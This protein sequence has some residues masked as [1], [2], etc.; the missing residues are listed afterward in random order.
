MSKKL[1]LSVFFFVTFI[2]LNS[3]E[4]SVIDFPNPITFQPANLGY[5]NYNVNEYV[6]SHISLS[7][8]LLNSLES[9]T[10]LTY[11]TIPNLSQSAFASTKVGTIRTALKYE[12]HKLE[13]KFKSFLY[14]YEH[15][16]GTDNLDYEYGGFFA[17]G[18]KYGF[19]FESYKMEDKF[20]DSVEY[21][22]SGELDAGEHTLISYKYDKLVKTKSDFNILGFSYKD[23]ASIIIN[24]KVGLGNRDYSLNLDFEKTYEYRLEN[25]FRIGDNVQR[26]IFDADCAYDC[27][28]Y[29]LQVGGIYSTDQSQKIATR[30]TAEVSYLSYEYSK[31]F[32]FSNTT[33]S[34]FSSDEEKI[35]HKNIYSMKLSGLE[36]NF[37]NDTS[38]KVTDKF[39]VSGIIKVNFIPRFL[40]STYP[41]TRN[42]KV[43]EFNS[44]LLGKY[45]LA[46][47]ISMRGGI[48]WNYLKEKKGG[49]YF[50]F[51]SSY[52]EKWKIVTENPE[53][54]TRL[55]AGLSLNPSK[56]ISLD[57]F[58]QLTVAD[59]EFTLNFGMEIGI[60]L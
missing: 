42:Q 24:L 28:Q 25:S 58:N 48:G 40:S 2:I 18:N 53:Y 31:P 57:L 36:L 56:N 39:T 3:Q 51:S 13:N 8:Y 49:H 15:S 52:D 32:Y 34:Y 16:Y 55:F 22:H 46:S 60:K 29:L 17:C 59:D 14:P 50:F 54:E 10:I 19:S 7:P 44:G 9:S 33:T 30:V 38:W 4:L 6:V 35:E 20:K 21:F 27:K 37:Q 12:K 41:E 5:W 47:F 45:Q 23:N 26:V 43:Y 11:N 1:F